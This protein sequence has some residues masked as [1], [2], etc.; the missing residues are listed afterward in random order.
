MR[1]IE[2]EWNFNTFD[3]LRLSISI[4]KITYFAN[5]QE[6][7]FSYLLSNINKMT[8]SKINYYCINKTM[9]HKVPQLISLN[10]AI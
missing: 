10:N 3:I 8:L 2:R 1:I 6:I 4:I 5:R 7:C 9:I